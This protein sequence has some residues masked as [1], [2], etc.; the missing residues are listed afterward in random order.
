MHDLI[1]GIFYFWCQCLST[2]LSDRSPRVDSEPGK[3]HAITEYQR[4]LAVIISTAVSYGDW[5]SYPLSF[6]YLRP[7][8]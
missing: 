1:I 8:P 7:V 6:F 3:Y 2:A 5:E 4:Q